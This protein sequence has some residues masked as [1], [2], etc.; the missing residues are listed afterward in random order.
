VIQVMI[1]DSN[2]FFGF[3][4]RRCLES[5]L[6][7]VRDIAR[8]HNIAKIAI[9]S[10]R[11]IFQDFVQGNTETIELAMHDEGIIPVVTVNPNHFLDCDPEIDRCIEN[12]IKLFRFFPEFQ[13]WTYSYRPFLRLLQRLSRSDAIVM[14]PTRLARHLEFG[15]ISD[16][17]RAVGELDIRCIMTDVY[18]GNLAE[19][20][21]VAAEHPGIMVES[22]LLNSPGAVE[23]LV[24]NLGFERLIF[25]SRSPLAYVGAALKPILEASVDDSVK[26]AILGT[27]IQRM[28]R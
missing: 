19:A 10:M 21:T 17:G 20:L 11:G 26:Q 8:Q 15:S 13:G 14:L 16:I 27:N 18:Y 3:W 4:P 28:L 12:G 7:T 5:S 22:H 6:D 2:V 24:N 9:C 25:G 23:L 1:I